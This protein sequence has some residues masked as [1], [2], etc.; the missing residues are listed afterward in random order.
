M[1]ANPELSAH[2]R[3]GPEQTRTTTAGPLGVLTSPAHAQQQ[4]QR[5]AKDPVTTLATLTQ[6]VPPPARPTATDWNAVET[7]LQTPLPTDYKH[8]LDTYGPGSLVSRLQ[9]VIST[10][11]LEGGDAPAPP[12]P[13]HHGIGR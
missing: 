7:L 1:Q 12:C 10:A 8:L 11:I 4:Q 13:P 9:K 3:H 6:L 2:N 5:R